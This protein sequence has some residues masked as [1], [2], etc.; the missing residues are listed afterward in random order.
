EWPALRNALAYAGGAAEGARRALDGLEIDTERMRA[1]LELTDGLVMAEKA[2]FLLARELGRREAHQKVAEA[3]AGGR[4]LAE[5][6][7]LGPAGLD[8]ARYLGSGETC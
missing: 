5:E 3:A 7:G 4:L 2:S 1:N 6:L 8:P